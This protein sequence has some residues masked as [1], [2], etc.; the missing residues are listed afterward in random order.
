M[1]GGRGGVGETGRPGGDKKGWRHSCQRKWVG[2][3]SGDSKLASKRWCSIP[4]GRNMNKKTNKRGIQAISVFQ[5]MKSLAEDQ[6]ELPTPG[7]R[8]RVSWSVRGLGWFFYFCCAQGK[9][10]TPPL[11]LCLPF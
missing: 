7:T 10:H 3:C 1:E 4:Y 5:P 8:I 11:S 6:R 2:C 9:P